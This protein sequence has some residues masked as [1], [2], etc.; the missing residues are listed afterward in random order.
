[1]T[2]KNIHFIIS[3]GPVITITEFKTMLKPKTKTAVSKT[4]LNPKKRSSVEHNC[5][6]LICALLLLFKINNTDELVNFINRMKN[7][8]SIYEQKIIFNHK[9]DLYKYEYDITKKT[10]TKT[11]KQK[12]NNCITNFNKAIQLTPSIFC[13]LENIAYIYISGKKNSHKEIAELNKGLCKLEAKSDI[14][15]KLLDNSFIGLSIKESIDATKCNY[16]VHKFLE[17]ILE[18]KSI[19]ELDMIKN[20]ILIENVYDKKNRAKVNALFYP[21]NNNPYMNAL[22]EYLNNNCVKIAEFL[23]EKLYSANIPY[24]IHEFNSKDISELVK[25]ADGTYIKFEEHLRYY[26]YKNDPKK[27]RKATKLFYRLTCG[28][29]KYRVEIRWKGDLRHA[30]QFQVHEDNE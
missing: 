27:E 13:N 9:D 3:D 2:T 1:M 30:I 8:I 22:K 16:S 12:I 5:M 10:K 21:C 7:D 19:I 11:K 18:K 6:E 20:K 17:T 4:T 15:I 29:K 23:V 28:N 26:Y 14:Y 25:I 24:L